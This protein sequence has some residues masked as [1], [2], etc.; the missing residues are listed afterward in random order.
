MSEPDH[1]GMPAAS[2]PI[3]LSYGRHAPDEPPPLAPSDTLDTVE[4]DTRHYRHDGWTPALRAS[5]LDMLAKSGVVTDACREVQQ[6]PG[7][8]R[9]AQPRPFVRRRVGRGFV[10]GPRAARR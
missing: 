1:G 8:V 10:D 7:G 5:F 9:A 6:Q 4:R 2:V 3:V